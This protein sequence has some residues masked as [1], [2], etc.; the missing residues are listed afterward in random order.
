MITADDQLI[1][2]LAKRT[3]LARDALFTPVAAGRIQKA[4]SYPLRDD[5]AEE[6][7]RRII[8]EMTRVVP[9]GST[10]EA[11]PAARYVW[12]QEMTAHYVW[13]QTRLVI[14]RISSAGQMPAWRSPGDGWDPRRDGWELDPD[15]DDADL[16]WAA[17]QWDWWKRVKAAGV[18]EAWQLPEPY[19]GADSDLPLDRALDAR[20]RTGDAAAYRRRLRQIRDANYRDIDA[21]AHS[22][23]DALARADAI[24]RGFLPSHDGTAVQGVDACCFQIG[25]DNIARDAGGTRQPGDVTLACPP[26]FGQEFAPGA[27]LQGRPVLQGGQGVG[28][29]PRGIIHPR[30]LDGGRASK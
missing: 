27:G 16:I 24:N 5:E 28:A 6:V 12:L 8:E 14:L 25:V 29:L 18:R 4:F 15:D 30:H 23:H 17:Q 22:G 1:T 11:D 10:A 21:W 2:V 3:G 9:I 13:A 26:S 20:H 7:V 19:V